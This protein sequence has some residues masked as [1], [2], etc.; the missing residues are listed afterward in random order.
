MKGWMDF[1]V[2]LKIWYDVKV[3]LTD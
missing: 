2:Q 3:G 1:V